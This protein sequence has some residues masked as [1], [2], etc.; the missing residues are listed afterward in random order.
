MEMG[1]SWEGGRKEGARKGAGG[2]GGRGGREG[3][4]GRAGGGGNRG[5]GVESEKWREIYKMAGNLKL[6]AP[7]IV[8]SVGA[9]GS[10]TEEESDQQSTD[11]KSTRQGSNLRPGDLQ[12]L[13]LPLSYWWL[14]IMGGKFYFYKNHHAPPPPGS[15]STYPVLDHI[16]GQKVGSLPAC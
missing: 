5:E 6:V 11:Q 1:L 2:K 7:K 8:W 9:C 13:A 4:R 16:F 15:Q 14:D 10:F 12:S 3:G